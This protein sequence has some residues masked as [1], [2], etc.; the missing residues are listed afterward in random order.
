[1]ARLC[2]RAKK[3]WNMKENVI[4]IIGGALGT[5]PKNLKRDWGTGNPKKNFSTV[6][7]DSNTRVRRNREFQ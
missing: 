2:Q 4:P 5:I 6:G 3:S 7:M 1:M